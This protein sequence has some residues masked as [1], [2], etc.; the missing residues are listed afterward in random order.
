M[1]NGWKVMRKFDEITILIAD[2][3]RGQHPNS[4]N[5]DILM[6]LIFQHL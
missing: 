6:Q 5:T 1:I 4:G 2:Y 3:V